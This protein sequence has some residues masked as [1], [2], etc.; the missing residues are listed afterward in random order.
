MDK[1]YLNQI[2]YNVMFG[3]RAKLEE[4]VIYM[5]LNK[6]QRFICK[7]FRIPTKLYHYIP[8]T[9]YQMGGIMNSIKEKKEENE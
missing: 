2:E 7:L 5:N 3:E 6:F 9:K 4:K 8:K 1:I